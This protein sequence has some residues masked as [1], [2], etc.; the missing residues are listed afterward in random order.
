MYEYFFA[1]NTLSLVQPPEGWGKVPTPV[2]FQDAVIQDGRKPQVVSLSQ[3]RLGQ[4][5]VWGPFQCSQFFNSMK[6]IALNMQNAE[7]CQ[8]FEDASQGSYLPPMCLRW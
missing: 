6:L 3:E 4:M 1:M 7:M 5:I 8:A 2:G